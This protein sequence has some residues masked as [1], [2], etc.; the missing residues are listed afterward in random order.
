MAHARRRRWRLRIRQRRVAE[1]HYS[2]TVISMRARTLLTSMRSAS[3][4]HDELRLP[5]KVKF[6]LLPQDRAVY[7]GSL[8]YHRDAYTVI[9]R[10]EVIDDHERA[11]RESRSAWAPRCSCGKRWSTRPA[12]PGSRQRVARRRTQ[13]M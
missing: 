3:L 5:G 2:G 1:V 8:R 10:V 12:E 4:D 11:N 13:S 7:L 9:T 6:K